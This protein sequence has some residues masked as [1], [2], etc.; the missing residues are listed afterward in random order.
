MYFLWLCGEAKGQ[1][2]M[3]TIFP[4]IIFKRHGPIPSSAHILCC[5]S[6]LFCL[7]YVPSILYSLCVC[8]DNAY[9]CCCV[10]FWFIVWDF[11][12]MQDHLFVRTNSHIHTHI[13]TDNNNLC[14][15]GVV[16]NKFNELFFYYYC[17]IIP[18]Y[19]NCIWRMRE[20]KYR[21][22]HL[23]YATE[24]NFLNKNAEKFCDFISIWRN[25]SE[26]KKCAY[27]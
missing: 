8:H 24:V 11:F 25:L 23:I 26:K 3:C 12:S 18:Q 27:Q 9:G 15:E 17:Q 5:P 20:R 22:L 2:T 10:F 16:V 19:L 6:P 7:A 21:E 4:I 1:S 13:Y 14:S